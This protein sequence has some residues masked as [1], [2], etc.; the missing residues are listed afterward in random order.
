MKT[1]D[2]SP[3]ATSL[4]NVLKSLEGGSAETMVS[5][6]LSARNALSRIERPLVN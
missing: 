3:A 5:N 4:S 2:L 1:Q 6:N